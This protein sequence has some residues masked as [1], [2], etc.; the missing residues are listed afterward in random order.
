MDQLITDARVAEAQKL[1]IDNYE[2]RI[3]ARRAAFIESIVARDPSQGVFKAGWMRKLNSIG[4]GELK[5]N[6]GKIYRF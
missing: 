6:Y 5:D 2:A 4:Y 3:K 1:M